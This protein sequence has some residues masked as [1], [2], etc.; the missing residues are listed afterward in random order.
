MASSQL[1]FLQSGCCQVCSLLDHYS[2]AQ[3]TFPMSVSLFLVFHPWG[4]F[5]RCVVHQSW[6]T[7]YNLHGVCMHVCV[8]FVFYVCP[9]RPCIDLLFTSIAPPLISIP[10]SI[11]TLA[12][13]PF[14]FSF[15]PL[16]H[17]LTFFLSKGSTV[18]IINMISTER[19]SPSIPEASALSLS[20]FP[21]LTSS[22][23]LPHSFSRLFYGTLNLTH[24]FGSIFISPSLSMF[25]SPSVPYMQSPLCCGTLWLNIDKNSLSPN[26]GEA[27]NRT[28]SAG[29]TASFLSFLFPN[30]PSPFLLWRASPHLT[31]C[32]GYLVR[33]TVPSCVCFSGC[34][35]SRSVILPASLRVCVGG[36]RWWWMGFSTDLLCLLVSAVSTCVS[37]LMTY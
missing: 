3:L 18:Y 15:I 28:L 13:P 8:C 31:I 33:L 14:P 34:F 2:K 25:L 35:L 24:S 5:S 32:P 17:T 22:P 12:L 9:L 19:S 4:F 23:D 11:P 37:G 16:I 29:Y 30:L 27:K 20:V 6:C 21:S 36:S 10:S 26:W 1:L 7:D